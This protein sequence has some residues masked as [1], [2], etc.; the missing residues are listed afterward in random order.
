MTQDS[1]AKLP[2]TILHRCAALSVRRVPLNLAVVLHS[3][4]TSRQSILLCPKATLA[5]QRYTFLRLT[6]SFTP[7]KPTQNVR[8]GPFGVRFPKSPKGIRPDSGPFRINLAMFQLI[9]SNP[10]HRM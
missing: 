10:P 3:I 7:R 8:L 1:A 9:Y 5:L 4:S 6:L 2:Y